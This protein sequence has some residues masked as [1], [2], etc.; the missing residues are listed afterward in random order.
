MVEKKT[1]VDYPRKISPDEI[2]R[3]IIEAY[4]KYLDENKMKYLEKEARYRSKHKH[5][6]PY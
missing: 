1:A 2:K 4:K 6:R 3:N 5:N